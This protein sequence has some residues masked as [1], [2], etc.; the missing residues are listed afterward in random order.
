MTKFSIK[1]KKCESQVVFDE[2][3]PS[4]EG[5][6]RECYM[7]KQKTLINKDDYDADD[8]ILNKKNACNNCYKQN[9]TRNSQKI[10]NCP[11]KWNEIR[12]NRD[13]KR[14]WQIFFLPEKYL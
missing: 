2:E 10:S 14:N 5:A 12:N 3:T 11:M 9:G 7:Q 13:R 6:C 4:H 8:E 1:K